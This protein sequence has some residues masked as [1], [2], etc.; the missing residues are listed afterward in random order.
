[1]IDKHFGDYILVCD[2]CEEEAEE[3]WST[4]KGKIWR[5]NDGKRS[6][7]VPCGVR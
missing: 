5:L 4:V 1:M 3:G 2:C 7:H 6:G